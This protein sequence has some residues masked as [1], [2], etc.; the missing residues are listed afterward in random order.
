MKTIKKFRRKRQKIER[1]I[2]LG[3]A[4]AAGQDQRVEA[5]MAIRRNDRLN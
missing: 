3:I 1:T 5:A 2:R 4:R